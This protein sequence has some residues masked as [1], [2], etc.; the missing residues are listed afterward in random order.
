MKKLIVL[1]LILICIFS[2]VGCDSTRMDLQSRFPEY[3]NLETFKG[4]E[5]YVWQEENGEYQC[6]ALSGTNR[7]KTIDEISNLTKNSATI[8]EMRVILSSYDIEQ[9]GIIIIP[10][11][12][13]TEDFEIVN[14]DFERIN[15]MFWEN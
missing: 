8:K 7:N 1:V 13:N 2:L 6:G 14:G 10:I 4:I 12:I 5:V 11:K 9:D 3:Y 15:E